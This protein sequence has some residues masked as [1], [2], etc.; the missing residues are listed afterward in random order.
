M[1]ED[2][3]W[4]HVDQRPWDDAI[5]L[6]RRRMNRC[7]WKV[8]LVCAVACLCTGTT[9]V[10][11]ADTELL[12]AVYPT[13][14]PTL[15][16]TTPAVVGLP[17][18][19]FN[20]DHVD[21]GDPTSEATH[22]MSENTCGTG[23]AGNACY[24]GDC[25]AYEWG[26]V[27]TW[28]S[29]RTIR[30]MWEQDGTAPNESDPS[31]TLTLD[32]GALSVNKY[33]AVLWNRGA[34]NDSFDITIDGDA[35]GPYHVAWVSG[36]NNNVAI[37]GVFDVGVQTGV[38][39]VTFTATAPAWGSQTTYGQAM[40]S[41]VAVWSGPECVDASDCDDANGCTDDACVAYECSNTNNTAPCDDGTYCNGADTCADGAC[42]VHAGDPCG[43]G[44]VCNED[45]DTCDEEPIGA[46]VIL[47]EYNAVGGSKWLDCNGL[48]CS[49]E[50]DIY[51]GRVEGNG[52]N[53]LELVVTID[54]LDM[55]NWTIDWSEDE[56]TGTITFA[57][58]MLWSDLRA[59]TIITLTEQCGAE[60]GK[61]T[62]TTF[63]PITDWWINI[64]T[65]CGG[66]E[67]TT[68]VTTT[69]SSAPAGSF[70]VGNDDFQV[71][72][73][74]DMANV[75]FGP[76]GE[77]ACDFDGVSSTEVGK[78]E[79]DP[80]AMITPCSAYNDGTSST[81]GAPNRWSGGDEKQDFSA[82]RGQIFDIQ[83]VTLST[84]SDSDAAGFKVCMDG[85]SFGQPCDDDVDCFGG[86]AGSCRGLAD[87][88]V[89]D[90]QFDVDETFYVE[91]W[92]Q[93]TDPAGVAAVY[94]DIEFDPCLVQAE[95]I[96]HT[97]AF[98]VS[99]VDPEGTIDN[100]HGLIDD[101]GGP[102]LDGGCSTS[103]GTAPNWVRAAYIEFTAEA[104]GEVTFSSRNTGS[105][106]DNAICGTLGL[107]DDERVNYGGRSG[108]LGTQSGTLALDVPS[109]P[110]VVATADQ[111]TVDLTVADLSAAINGVQALVH[112][113][114]QNLSL[115]SITPAAPWDAELNELHG[116]CV[117]GSED[118]EAC[119]SVGGADCIDGE[120][121]Q[122]GD[123]LYAVGISGGSTSDDGVVATLTFDAVADSTPVV[124]LQ[125][126]MPDVYPT[127]CTKLTVASSA[128]AVIPSRTSTGDGD[129]RILDEECYIDGESYDDGD[130]NPLSECEVCDWET[131]TTSW[132]P[133]AAGTACG[134]DPD[135]CENQDTCDGAGVCTD[136]GLK[137][138]DTVCRAA[139]GDCDV[140]E[141][142]DGVS[143]SCPD[144]AFADASTV[145]R[146]GAGDCDVAE[147]CPGD[148]ADCPDDLVALDGTP[149]DDG[150]F[151]NDGETCQ[152]G[153]CTG[154]A[155]YDCSGLDDQ[156]AQGVC[157]EDADACVA[158]PINE[159]LGCDDGLFCNDGE[160]CQ[161]GVCTGGTPYDCSGLDDQCAQ[162]VCDE[163]AD[164][165]VADPINEGLGCD[166]GLFCNDGETC[167]SGACTGGAPYD[168]S[169]LDDQCAQG[170][171]DEDADACVADPINEGLG[172][173][174][175]LFCNDGETCQS[176]AC[177]G[178]APYDCSGLDDQCAQGVCDEDADACVADPINEGLGCD[179]GLFCNDGETCQSGACTGGAPYDCSGLDDQCAQGVCDEDADACVA[180]PINEGLGCD[181]GLFCNDGET[182]QSGACTG[183]APYDCSGLDDQCAQGVC[184]EDADACVADPINEGLGCDDGLFCNDGETCQ[185]GACT[186]GTPYDC[187]G[188]DDQCAQGVC[189]EDADACVADPINEGLGCDDGLFCNDGETC[190]SGACT[191]GTPYDCSGLDDQ[192]AQG[193]CDEDADAC[194]A[195]PINEGLGCD[196]GLFCNDGETCQS[197]ACTGGAPYDCS[198]LDDQCAQGVCD[199]DADACVADP[200]NEGLGCD[201]GLFCNDGETCQS[202]ACTGGAPYD[203][204]G[205]D[206]QCAQGVCDEDADACVADPINEGLGCDDGLF[207]NDGETC[208]SGACTG[209]TPYDCSGLDDQCA[210]GV[211]DEDADACVADPINEG[212]GCDDG[213]FC[214]EG[215]TCQSG[216]CTGGTPYDCSGLD[217]QCAQGVCDEDADAC[218]ADPINEG[219]GC[220]DGLFCNEGETCQ[221]G[222]CTG[223]APRDCADADVCTA[224]TCDEVNDVCEH[225]DVT[226]I[227]VYI[228]I[229]ALSSAVT[230]EV[231]FVMTDCEGDRVSRTEPVAFDSFGAGY[232]TLTDVDT[233]AD[234]IQAVE[235]HTL[236]RLLPLTFDVGG[237]CG[238]E[239]YFTGDDELLS[240]DFSNAW[241][242]QDGLVDIQDFAILS[243]EWNNPVDPTLGSLADATGDGVQ[244]TFDFAPI[245]INFAVAGDGENGCGLSFVSASG[246]SGDSGS[247]K[248]PLW[249]ARKDRASRRSTDRLSAVRGS[250]IRPTQPRLWMAVADLNV[251]NAERADL[252]GDGVI[253]AA[254]IRTFAEVHGILLSTELTARLEQLDVSQAVGEADRLD[255]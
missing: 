108:Q 232:V 191:G 118:G 255:R 119:G 2:L 237:G 17:E 252:N 43:T 59:G 83:L 11:G 220:D 180:D 31:A 113:N 69:H 154:G 172:C 212:L 79:E 167:Q 193:V 62:D 144:D 216:A 102:H 187:S 38:H 146:A 33:V 222:A 91:V 48:S 112:Y 99:G 3:R 52:G 207:C 53:W 149:C 205:L 130:P 37:T 210:Q 105:G 71:T 141:L 248:A 123:V 9:V 76:A 106:L 176:G 243:I 28:L 250:S 115:V 129:I 70:S 26:G 56:D 35:G 84:P 171:C 240:G 23:A 55:R 110:Q 206:D 20:V 94:T 192:C 25:S 75:V 182:C 136:N 145:C 95:A 49:D 128:E 96:Y 245:Q 156:C 132:T 241:V 104:H 101:V 174:D 131:S 18:G 46:P 36:A 218:V 19:A 168:C 114:T 54:H 184:D 170:V 153:A 242:A 116:V 85:M 135:A 7:V 175:G 143:P 195:D 82:L 181:D 198:G 5:L 6:G 10:M 254:D 246:Q 21:V 14:E 152:S 162:G 238:A 50:E 29:G 249:S 151:C 24:G 155:P 223:G 213:L 64:N 81:F 179:D 134:A 150:L 78:L 200:I 47:N 164:A 139:A 44:E 32:F 39:T 214:N 60:G 211:C 61:D 239:V 169:G 90:T 80:S 126:G 125:A 140:A 160:T 217:D 173:D 137:T 122:T 40:I 159:G 188:L 227:D 93:T 235:G 166:D 117:G 183:G 42:T 92:A 197:G 244:D 196:D 165:C 72:I 97:T 34:G 215:E 109:A 185:S 247:Q 233:E 27:C 228:E 178:G 15:W 204:S 253:D 199:E 189:D 163:D 16:T 161:S 41:E 225:D 86:S 224:D 100:D 107:V 74:D 67:Q 209:G 121:V 251:P 4:L 142:C 120:C 229:D 202:G 177:T 57:D 221:S 226:F 124:S 148:G 8:A 190:Q 186:G 65:L 133:L 12:S 1:A 13:S 231:T 98:Y 73:K 147:F 158:D 22:G 51:F 219:L 236:S 127:L 138:A 68:Y 45:D 88:P 111:V 208:Q 77:G 58:D 203:C 87:L 194:V 230:R 66:V 157:D 30:A 89:S 234:W 103:F 201:D 63:N